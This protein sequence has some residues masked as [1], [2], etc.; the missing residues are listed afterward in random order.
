[1]DD[2]WRLVNGS[3]LY[4]VRVDKRYVYIKAGTSHENPLRISSHDMLS[5]NMGNS[6]HQYGAVEAAEG[7]GIWK[8]E[9]VEEGDYSICLRRFPR[10]SGWGFNAQFPE[11][12]KSIELERSMPACKQVGFV[13]ASLYI[14]D[15]SKVLAI[16]EEAEEVEF[17]MHL[18]PGKYDM[19]AIL[20][21]KEGSIHPAYFVYL[22][23]VN[24]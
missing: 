1:M 21:D 10:E 22:E 7:S 5:D 15:F 8:V 17:S 13:E 23:K 2:T 16:D 14:A 12:P 4:N 9:I 18:H 11:T 19:E 6:W 3:E 20:K 24:R